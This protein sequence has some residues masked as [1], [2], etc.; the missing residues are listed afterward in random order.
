MP[1]FL[2]NFAKIC[3]FLTPILTHWMSPDLLVRVTLASITCY[4]SEGRSS[5]DTFPFSHLSPQL[6]SNGIQASFFSSKPLFFHPS[7]FFRHPSFFFRHPSKSWDLPTRPRSGD[8]I[9]PLPYLKSTPAF[10]FQH[11]G[12]SRHPD[13]LRTTKWGVP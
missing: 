7:F 12:E 5:L 1:V 9:S 4:P 2:K 8:Q 6:L 3:N 13:T 11:P 10:L